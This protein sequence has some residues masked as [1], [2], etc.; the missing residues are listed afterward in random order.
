VAASQGRVN[1]SQAG[2]VGT[3]D[4]VIAAS[5]VAA[6]TEGIPMGNV[7]AAVAV[8]HEMA[9]AEVAASHAAAPEVA[10]A[11]A[12]TT[13][14]APTTSATVASATYAPTT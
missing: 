5:D 8:G 10:T 13:S 7:A 1:V 14:A 11:S 4:A 12:T 9:S 6:V 3:H 2:S